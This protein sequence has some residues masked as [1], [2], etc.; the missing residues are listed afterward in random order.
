VSQQ[1]Q[2][3]VGGSDLTQYVTQDAWSINQNWSRQGD[4]ASFTLVDE[5]PQRTTLTFTVTPLTTV[6]MRDVG[7]GVTLFSGVCTKPLVKFDSPNLATWSLDC[8]D[9]TYL[10]DRKIVVGDYTN[11]T[12]DALAILLCQQFPCGVSAATPANGGFVQPGPQIPRIQFNYDTLTTAW[13]KISKLV[14]LNTTYGWYVDENQALH[15]NT[16]TQ[17]TSS[18]WTLTDNI[19]LQGT[20]GYQGYDNDSF[21]YE[22]DAT[23]I[24]N[25]VTV[26]GGDY[27]QSQTDLF[28]GNGSTAAFPLT[29]VPD[30][31]NI[32]QAALTVGGVASTVSAQ[33]GGN[34]TTAWV[35]VGN[36]ANQWFLVP[37]TDP[38]PAGST[39][40]SLTYPYLQPVVSNVSDQTSIARF[41]SLP[42]GGSFAYYIGDSSLP[43]LLAAQVRGQREVNTYSQPTERATVTLTEN[44]TGH[45][46]AGQTITLQNGMVPDSQNNNTPGLSDTFLI[47]QNR[48]NGKQGLYR[49]YG[50]TAARI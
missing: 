13:T 50:L 33:T 43:T 14:S 23:S 40:V 22:W 41:K 19:A 8:V 17:A 2:L 39:I 46:R 34:A 6:V 32:A 11:Y 18:G 5:H 42:N 29:F 49:T 26:R 44:F 21:E 30:A 10:S 27:S 36:A 20:A 7:L 35:I 25:S 31:N 38:V 1:L 15:F 47:L 16:L 28:V 24:R 3:L 45:V 12:A 48:I 37:N 4:T 9:W